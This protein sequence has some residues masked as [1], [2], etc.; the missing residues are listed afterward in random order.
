MH[1]RFRSALHSSPS[2]Q[3]VGAYGSG[4]RHFCMEVTLFF[5]KVLNEM[6][7]SDILLC[8]ESNPP[9]TS[10]G[11]P[12]PDGL[13]HGSRHHGGECPEASAGVEAAEACA[14]GGFTW[15][16]KD[17]PGGSAGKSFWKPPGQDQPVRANGNGSE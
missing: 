16:G 2:L 12:E 4:S 6:P 8:V 5:A 7:G 15:R 11:E 13:R 14:A 17:Q 3:N 10:D 9:R 1:A